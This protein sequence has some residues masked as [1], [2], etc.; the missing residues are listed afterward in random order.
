MSTGLR[1]AVS[2]LSCCLSGLGN[3]QI[4]FLKKKKSENRTPK[5]DESG[6]VA[7]ELLKAKIMENELQRP[8]EKELRAELL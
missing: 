8:V 2:I 4:Y 3:E 1:V 5:I 7:C 6:E